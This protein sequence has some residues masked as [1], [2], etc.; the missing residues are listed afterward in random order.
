MLVVVV[1]VT[2]VSDLYIGWLVLTVLVIIGFMVD[3]MFFL[4][5]SFVF[6]PD[7]R[8][9]QAKTKTDDQRI[10]GGDYQ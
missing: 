7:Y 8:N 6:D 9:W 2:N 10:L 4:D 5:D 3:C 1:F